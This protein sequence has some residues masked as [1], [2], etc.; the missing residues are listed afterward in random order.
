MNSHD[1]DDHGINVD[2]ADPLAVGPVNAEAVVLPHSTAT[3]VP[4]CHLRDLPRAGRGSYARCM[5][6]TKLSVSREIPAP[7]HEIFALL[8][9]PRRHNEFD[10]SD[11]VGRPLEPTPITAVGDVFTMQM[12]F[13]KGD[14]T[15]HEYV[16]ENHVSIFHPGSVIAWKTASRGKPPYGWEWRY[17]LTPLGSNRTRV[18]LSYDFADTTAEVRERFGLP[19]WTAEDF[20][21][22]LT[23]LEQAVLAAGPLTTPTPSLGD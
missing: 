7:A 18:T 9:D 17:D 16:T 10:A 4:P 21:N 12:S 23:M 20:Q 8:S 3:T 19:K 6:Q 14:G 11:M 22:S 5:T 15:R 2:T 1:Y 13:D